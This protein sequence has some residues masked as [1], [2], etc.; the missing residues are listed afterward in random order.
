MR[1]LFD[2]E[3][4]MDAGSGVGADLRVGAVAHRADGEESKAIVNQGREILGLKARLAHPAFAQDRLVQIADSLSNK[5]I[6][7][8]AVRVTYRNNPRIFR[9]SLK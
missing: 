8:F 3:V 2:Y 4:W 9:V 7:G 1:A 5:S 6:R